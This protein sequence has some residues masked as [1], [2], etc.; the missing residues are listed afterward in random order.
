MA[1]VSDSS[2]LMAVLRVGPAAP[3]ALLSPNEPCPCF[4]SA[5][6]DG[7]VFLWQAGATSPWELGSCL[8]SFLPLQTGACS[9][10]CW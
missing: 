6:P 10:S 3:Y 7:H 2:Y 8:M 5:G 4:S 1:F 9:D